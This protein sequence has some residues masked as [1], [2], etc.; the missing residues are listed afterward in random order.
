[1]LYTG[2]EDLS[3]IGSREYTNIKETITKNIIFTTLP[4][5]CSS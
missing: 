2:A 5:A 4:Q 3:E 1:M